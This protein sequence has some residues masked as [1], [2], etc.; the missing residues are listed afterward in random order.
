MDDTDLFFQS[1]QKVPDAG[2]R[3]HLLEE[4]LNETGEPKL[5]NAVLWWHSRYRFTDRKRTRVEDRYLWLLLCL[6]NK[7]KSLE[8]EV[9]RAYKNAMLSDETNAAMAASDL[10]YETML[11]ASEFYM[12]TLDRPTTIF[13]VPRSK[14][15]SGEQLLNLVAKTVVTD[16]LCRLWKTCAGQARIDVAARAILGAARNIYPESID[17]LGRYISDIKDPVVRQFIETAALSTESRRLANTDI[18]P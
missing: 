6:F 5:R 18:I 8:K 15:L 3:L 9:S 16:A 10:L 12:R 14:R 2:T 13:G 7:S 1:L 11:D 17:V 4:K